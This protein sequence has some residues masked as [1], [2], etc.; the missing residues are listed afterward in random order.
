MSPARLACSLPPQ[1]V[2]EQQPSGTEGLPSLGVLP[3]TLSLY[4]RSSYPMDRDNGSIWA[5]RGLSTAFGFGLATHIGPLTISLYPEADWSQNQ[6][7]GTRPTHLRDLSEFAYGW[8]QGWIDWPQRMG[9]QATHRLTPGESFAELAGPLESR[10]GISN[11]G[12]WWGPS[13][14][15]P[16]MLGTTAGGFPHAY[17]TTPYVPGIPG[18]FQVRALVGELRESE[19]FDGDPA[20]DRTLMAVVRAEWR[21]R[22]PSAPMLAVT[23]LLRRQWEPGPTVG[24]FK[25]LVTGDAAQ[26]SED[27][28]VDRLAAVELLLPEIVTGVDLWGA[29][30]RGD[31]FLNV[32]DLLTEPEHSQF[33][34]V[35]LRR[36]WTRED[37]R[38]SISGEHAFTRASGPQFTYRGYSTSVYRHGLNSQ[39]HTNRG[40][41]LAA[42]IGPGAVADYVRLTATDASSR[43][44]GVLV[45]RILWDRDTHTRS[46]RAPYGPYGADFQDTEWL[47]GASLDTPRTR[48][49]GQAVGVS[50]TVGVAV[51]DNR[52][53]TNVPEAGDPPRLHEHNLWMDLRL[54]WAAGG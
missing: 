47:L 53:Y 51:R 45:E 46:V 5:G 41:L 33:W 14:R 36:Q 39:G 13:P 27:F 48:I 50:L 9:D 15:Y 37:V 7:F 1:D 18:L 26:G 49:V 23:S 40:Q 24:D 31:F 29:W 16:L 4:Y 43:T 11:E 20:N 2:Q 52:R 32:E 42:S 30:G 21:G 38:W 17:L 8:E 10:V 35:G 44:V 34:N 6:D 3:A 19:F 12:I 22:S 25:S 54:V 28:L